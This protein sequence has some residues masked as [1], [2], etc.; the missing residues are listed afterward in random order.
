MF[1]TEED[2]KFEWNCW[3][4]T[5]PWFCNVCQTFL[6][7]DAYVECDGTDMGTPKE[8]WQPHEPVPASSSLDYNEYRLIALKRAE[9]A[10]DLNYEEE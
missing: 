5:K 1:L 2:I 9:A 3:G 10:K 6:A 4:D 8:N 7:P